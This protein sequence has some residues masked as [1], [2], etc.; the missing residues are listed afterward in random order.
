MIRPPPKSTRTDTPVPY[1]TP[2][3]SSRCHAGLPQ[4]PQSQVTAKERAKDK[5]AMPTITR[6]IAATALIVMAAEPA[7]AY[8]GP[9]AGLSLLAAFWA[10]FKIG[11]AHV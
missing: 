7:W 11:R 3:R 2:F 9:G 4:Q 8:V 6:L 1:P 5:T 10:L